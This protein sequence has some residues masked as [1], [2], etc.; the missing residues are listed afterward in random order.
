MIQ[1]IKEAFKL[2]FND[3]KSLKSVVK[4]ENWIKPLGLIIFVSFIMN[5][6]GA[7]LMQGLILIVFTVITTFLSAGLLHGFLIFFGGKANFN[8][9]FTVGLHMQVV[10]TLVFFG[11]FILAQLSALVSVLLSEI[12][13]FIVIVL[14]LLY[15]PW[16]LM[17][18]TMA[19]SKTHSISLGKTYIAELIS[20]VLTILIFSVFVGLF[21]Y[22]VLPTGVIG[23][24]L[25]LQGI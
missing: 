3:E 7:S 14:I 15:V 1:N 18:L 20:L 19:L 4:K 23:N 10:P 5:S 11:L 22:L 24:Y 25:T 6:F 17:I 2:F 13:S 12:I 21:V 16:F 9:T 8:K